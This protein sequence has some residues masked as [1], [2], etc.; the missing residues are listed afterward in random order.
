MSKVSTKDQMKKDKRGSFKQI[1]EKGRLKSIG[2]SNSSLLKCE[3]ISKIYKRQ[4][5]KDVLKKLLLSD[6]HLLKTD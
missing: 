6:E 4:I 2:F 3:E 1:L 5:E